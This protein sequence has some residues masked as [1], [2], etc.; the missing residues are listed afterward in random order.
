MEILLLFSYYFL[1]SISII[2]FGNLSK[3]FFKKSSSFSELGFRGLLILI[4]ISYVTNFFLSHSFLHNSI[5][6]LLGL[7]SF[8]FFVS[9]NKINKQTYFLFFVV[10]LILFISLLMYK[11]HDDFFYYHFPYTFSLITQKKIIGIGLIEHGF[12]TP[13][14]LFYLNSLFYL[15]LIDYFLLNA[16][17]TYIMGFSNLFFLEKII[18][19]LKEKKTNIILFLSLFSLLVTNT[20]FSRIAEHGTDRSALI[21]IFV[22]AI[23]YLESLR[24]GYKNNQNRFIEYYEKIII[25][26]LLIVSLKSF[27]MIY[28]IIFLVWIFHINLNVFNKGINLNVFNKKILNNILI[29]KSTYVLI[30]GFLIFVSTVFLNTGCLIYPAS[31][32]CIQGIEWGIPLEQVGKMKNW[33]S[34]WSKAG[35]NPNF[36]VEN[37]ELYLSNFNWINNWINSYFF[38]KVSDFLIVLLTISILS[39][40]LLKNRKVKN[41]SVKNDY[42]ILFFL[43]FCLFI[44]WFLNHP[45]LRYGGYTLIALLFFLPLSSYLNKFSVY[46]KLFKKKLILLILLSF[47]IFITKNII[48]INDEMIKYGY[49]PLVN[50]YYY[51]NEDAFYFEKKISQIKKSVNQKNKKNYLILNDNLINL[52]N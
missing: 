11:N 7:I 51:L 12:R 45:S 47:G 36:R 50:P 15:P 25:I 1:I 33:Y 3:V 8:V 22:F 31:F 32:T 4:L 2:G 28:M 17:A 49:Q 10:F 44:E 26:L 6:I 40:F 39:I 5:L 43:I 42:K 13:S 20:V 23:Y 14:S 37:P 18:Y 46:S 41:L 9:H 27:Y 38:T 16:G 48:R 21:L 35:A 30:T 24:T 19:Y 52:K 29:N 34:L